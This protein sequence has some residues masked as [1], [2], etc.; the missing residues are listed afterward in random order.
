MSVQFFDSPEEMFEALEESIKV[1]DANT[2]D[3]QQDFEA[4]DCFL[5][6]TNLGFHIYAEIIKTYPEGRLKNYYFCKAYSVACPDGEMG[7]I[8]ACSITSRIDREIFE[9]IKKDLQGEYN[10]VKP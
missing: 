2:E 7:D 8:H 1:A 9:V 10:Y 5:Q 6:A 3:W 4:G